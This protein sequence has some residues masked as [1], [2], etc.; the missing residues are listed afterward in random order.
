MCADKV[1]KQDETDGTDVPEGLWRRKDLAEFLCVSDRW[2]DRAL[3]RAKDE[4]G[5][6]PHV[7][8]PTNG[9]RRFVRFVPEV[10]REWARLGFPAVAD[11]E[12]LVEE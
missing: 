3:T 6:L 11:F 9:S 4:P 10:I 1:E 7:E 2:V 8:L 5:S 12:G